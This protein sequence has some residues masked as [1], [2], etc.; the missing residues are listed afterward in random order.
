MIIR[1]VFWGLALWGLLSLILPSQVLYYA[2]M[3]LG[4]LTAIAV[5]TFAVIIF[6]DWLRV[7]YGDD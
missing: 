1:D 6:F 5:C 7:R 3:I 2:Y 4:I